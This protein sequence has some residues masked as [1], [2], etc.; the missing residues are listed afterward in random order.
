MIFV[1]T[2]VAVVVALSVFCFT[3]SLPS[4]ALPPAYLIAPSPP[5]LWP[6]HPPLAIRAALGSDTDSSGAVQRPRVA[7]AFSGGGHRAT[8]AS[9]AI[10]RAIHTVGAWNAVTH[11]GS[12]SGGSWFSSQLVHSARFWNDLSNDSLPVDTWVSAWVR[13]APRD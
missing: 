9:M 8:T 5:N 7:I 6:S 11:I 1:A 3:D 4:T 10:S 13:W 12:V 2:L